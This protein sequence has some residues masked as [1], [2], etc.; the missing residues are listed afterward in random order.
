[1]NDVIE[2]AIEDVKAA[3]KTGTTNIISI[4]AAAVI[5]FLSLVGDKA[6]EVIEDVQTELSEVVQEEE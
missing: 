6:D 1:M 5:A 2:R 3:F 4:I